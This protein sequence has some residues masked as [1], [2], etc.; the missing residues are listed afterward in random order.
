[1]S[2]SRLINR[3]IM[4]ASGRTSMRLEPEIWDAL[5]EMCLREGKDLRELMSM[6]ERG[7][8]GGGRTS[9]VRVHVLEYFRAAAT[10]AGHIAAGH[11]TSTATGQL[12]MSSRIEVD[13]DD[14][15]PRLEPSRMQAELDA[16]MSEQAE[17]A[18]AS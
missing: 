13:M 14:D 11:G 12:Q 1:M 10:D 4:A 3:N 18:E 16:Q 6:V 7:S 17:Y 15:L 8:Q 2:T 9:A 5:R